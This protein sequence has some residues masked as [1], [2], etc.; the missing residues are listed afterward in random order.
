MD[1][2]QPWSGSL[3]VVWG[4]EMKCH[5]CTFPIEN[6]QAW[7]PVASSFENA[8]LQDRGHLSCALAVTRNVPAYPDKTGKWCPY[9]HPPTGRWCMA[10][11]GHDGGHEL[12]PERGDEKATS[13]TDG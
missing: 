9:N 4:V 13:L 5:Y 8:P 10:A 11:P 2:H 7:V 12:E 6:G 1:H 3:P